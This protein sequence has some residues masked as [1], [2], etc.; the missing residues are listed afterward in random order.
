MSTLLRW[1]LK[2]GYATTTSFCV[3]LLH[4]EQCNLSFCYLKLVIIADYCV[5]RFFHTIWYWLYINN[6]TLLSSKPHTVLKFFLKVTTLATWDSVRTTQ[7]I[8][9]IWTVMNR[10]P[11]VGPDNKSLC[12]YHRLTISLSQ[13]ENISLWT[14]LDLFR[15]LASVQSPRNWLEDKLSLDK[16]TCPTLSPTWSHLP[17]M[18]VH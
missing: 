8:R 16:L 7:I 1:K 3:E 18:R 10:L 12:S 11:P 17:N 2:T 4:R 15:E 13:N 5:D 6:C 14:C 9:F